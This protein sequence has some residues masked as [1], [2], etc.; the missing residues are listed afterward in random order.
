MRGVIPAMI[1][2][3]LEHRIGQP[4]SGLFDFIAGTSTGGII[5]A[6]LTTP[7][8]DGTPKFTGKNLVEIYKEDGPKIF[9]HSLWHQILAVGSVVDAKYPSTGVKEVFEQRM[10]KLELKDALTELL[11]PAFELELGSPFFFKRHEAR[12][13]SYKN[14]FMKDVVLST[15]AAPTYFEPH[16]IKSKDLSKLKHLVFVDGGVVA[17]NPAMCAYLEAKHLFP[18]ADEYLVVS[19]GTGQH[20]ASYLYEQSRRWGAV[21]WLKPLLRILLSGSVDIVD[22]QLKILFHGSADPLNHY[23]RFQVPLTGQDSLL[24]DV[25]EISLH[26]L[27]LMAEN[28]IVENHKKIDE[29]CGLLKSLYN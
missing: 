3:E 23:Y 11:V 7:A 25:E 17:G 16:V 19:L 29:L 14:F 20:S 13:D 21:Q 10:G 26:K 24:D 15:M 9:S 6:Y 27:Q 2:A 5:A 18:D 12:A 4:M 1:I 22:H 28:F 8:K